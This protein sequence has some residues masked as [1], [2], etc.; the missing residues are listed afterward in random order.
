LD[1]LGDETQPI[2]YRPYT[3]NAPADAM[4][5]QLRTA[6]DPLSYANIARDTVAIVDPNA[7]VGGV[8]TKDAHID[9]AISRGITLARLSVVF[10]ALALATSCVGLYAAVAFQV[11]QRTNEIGVRMALGATR[12]NVAW[13]T[14]RRVVVLAAAGMV[15]GVP[16]AL[17]GAR[18]TRSF[19]FGI[20]PGDVAT[21][22]LAVGA[23][24][25]STLVAAWLPTRRASSMDP[26]EALRHD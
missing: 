20:E 26:M 13:L 10:A 12:W 24:V 16:A 1:D 9:Q 19:L 22:A 6:A 21:L 2:V 23:L 11:S 7:A 17:A 14:A 15:L 18:L 5:I 25:L 8:K 3:Q 4:T